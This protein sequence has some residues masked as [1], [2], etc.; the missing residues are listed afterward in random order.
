MNMKG[1]PLLGEVC[2]RL[3]FKTGST[4]AA[5]PYLP[6]DFYAP[7]TCSTPLHSTRLHSIHLF[8]FYN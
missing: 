6:T 8:T 3:Y 2:G 4:P 1:T 7:E 5:A